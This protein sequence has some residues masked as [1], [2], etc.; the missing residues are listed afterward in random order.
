MNRASESY[1]KLVLAI[2]EHDADYVDAY[3]GPP[4]WRDG[5]EGEEAVARRD[6]T[7]G[8]ASRCT[9]SSRA[10]PTPP[11]RWRAL[12]R[13]YL[14]RQTEA[15]LARVEMLRG[16]KLTFD[17]ESQALYDAVA[18]H[19][20]EAYFEELTARARS[21]AARQRLARRP[22]ATRS[23]KTSSSRRT[24]STPS[25]RRRS[26]AAARARCST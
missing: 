5:G 4:E 6:P 16:K 23:G 12:R 17:E 7:H 1:V 22:P 2:G 19:N 10:M 20:A 3:Y 24:S 9:T 25:S 8:A 13:E 11:T 15:L 21:R 26:T 18:P 14:A